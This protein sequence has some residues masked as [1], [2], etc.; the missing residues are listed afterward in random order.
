[1]I[2]YDHPIT[3]ARALALVKERL[4]KKKGLTGID[5]TPIK[6]VAK[7]ESLGVMIDCSRNAVLKV[8]TVKQFMRYLALMGYKTLQLYTEDTYELE[9]YP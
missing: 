8:E 9:G 5:R 1:M 4:S 7:F 6:Q 2:G 3:Y